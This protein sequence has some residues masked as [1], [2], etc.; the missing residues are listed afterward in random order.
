MLMDT[1]HPPEAP[2]IIWYLVSPK[3]L[4]INLLT[5][6]RMLFDRAID[7]STRQRDL[8]REATVNLILHAFLI[9]DQLGADD[10]TDL[11]LQ[12]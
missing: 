11:G 6:Q 1:V 12:L 8:F 9:L 4:I 2:T 3:V 7:W 10:R 5:I